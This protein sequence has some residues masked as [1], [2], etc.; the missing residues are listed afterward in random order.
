MKHATAIKAIG[1]AAASAMVVGIGSAAAAE[2]APAQTEHPKT[3]PGELRYMGPPTPEKELKQVVTP[4]APPLSEDEFKHATKI[5]FER[6][7]GCHGVLR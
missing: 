5:Y 3:T 2:Q 7:A 1:L 4:G 6:C